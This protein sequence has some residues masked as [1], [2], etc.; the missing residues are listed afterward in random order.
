MQEENF[1]VPTSTFDNSYWWQWEK[2][3]R[4]L[5][6]Y[7][8]ASIEFIKF[9]QQELEKNWMQQDKVLVN[10]NWNLINA[11]QVSQKALKESAE[12]RDYLFSKAQEITG[13]KNG[14]FYTQVWKRLNKE[15]NL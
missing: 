13:T 12:L 10:D 4:S 8:I 15:A 2:L 7:Y 6:K 1:I 11:K 14:F 5:L 9:K 3:H